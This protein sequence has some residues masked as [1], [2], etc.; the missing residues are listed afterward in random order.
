MIR[1]IE[2]REPIEFTSL[3]PYWQHPELNGNIPANVV[4]KF[5][6]LTLIQRPRLAFE[7]QLIDDG[8]GELN[9]YYI[10]KSGTIVP[11][12]SDDN[13][14]FFS[15]DCYMLHYYVAVILLLFVLFQFDNLIFYSV[16]GKEIKIVGTT[17]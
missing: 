9:V 10:S 1:I 12:K 17:N 2:G 13:I 5:D 14:A 11:L 4:G 16:P 3:F 15:R 6:A 8:S 7:T